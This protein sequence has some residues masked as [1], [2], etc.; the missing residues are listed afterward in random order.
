MHS[1]S[2]Q[3]VRQALAVME[4]D[5]IIWRKQGSGT[6]VQT[7]GREVGNQRST[8]GVISTYFS[9]YIFPSI[10]TGIERVLAKNN[11]TMQLA[12]THNQVAEEARALQ[13]MLSQSI[14][15]LI[16]EPSK[17][18]LPNPN[19]ALYEEIRARN[20]PLVFFN[21]K[22]PYS[23]FPCVAMNDV[24]AG[25]IV[26]EHLISLGHRKISAI[27]VSDDIQGHK[28]YQG[29]MKSLDENGISMAEQRVMWFSTQERPSLFTISEEKILA[30]LKD[31]TAIVCY[32]DSIAISLLELCKLRGIAVPSDISIVGIDDS[33]QARICEVPL[34]TVRHPQ[35]QL[36]ERAAEILLDIIANPS[37]STKDVLF[38]PKLIVRSSAVALVANA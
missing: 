36:G 7:P 37:Q 22:Y 24:D 17:G 30:L 31:S 6:F 4:R 11:V 21:A 19:T 1:V 8:V 9:D 32:N 35:Q 2:R 5:G 13:S 20:I 34:S 14:K 16:V 23:S 3:T 28:R 12:T 27:L 33:S 25:Y 10:V 15:G 18:A 29:F 38:T 26:T